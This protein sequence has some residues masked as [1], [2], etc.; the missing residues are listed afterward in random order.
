M[1]RVL[2]WV[3]SCR[4]F[5]VLVVS[6]LHI[7]MNYSFPMKSCFVL[8]SP[9]AVR[10]WSRRRFSSVFAAIDL[11]LCRLL[12]REHSL[13]YSARCKYVETKVITSVAESHLIGPTDVSQGILP[14]GVGVQLV[15]RKPN[16][17]SCICQRLEGCKKNRDNFACSSTNNGFPFLCNLR[18]AEAKDQR[19]RCINAVGLYLL[20]PKL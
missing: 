5:E 17:L 1:Y 15:Y 19:N 20:K 8:P 6:Y 12:W 16:L 18:A 3:S 10:D 14:I 11:A 9:R 13:F 2:N 7:T 4:E